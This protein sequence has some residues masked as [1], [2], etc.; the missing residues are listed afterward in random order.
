MENSNEEDLC[1]SLQLLSLNDTN[2]SP[3]VQDENRNKTD[4][5]YSNIFEE[6]V[7]R[8]PIK[9]LKS[10]FKHKTFKYM[11]KHLINDFKNNNN[12]SMFLNNI[13]SKI[14]LTL[15]SHYRG[16]Y[17]ILE[18]I[19]QSNAS[20]LGIIVSNKITLLNLHNFS[21][22][23]HTSILMQK[24]F[25]RSDVFLKLK[26]IEYLGD[27]L[28]DLAKSKYG[29]YLVTQMLKELAA[30]IRQNDQADFQQLQAVKKHYCALV[31]YFLQL[32]VFLK[33]CDQKFG[34]YIIELCTLNCDHYRKI[35]LLYD[36]LSIQVDNQSI[37]K[38]LANGKQSNYVIQKLCFFFNSHYIGQNNPNSYY[39]CYDLFFNSQHIKELLSILQIFR[40]LQQKPQQQEM[41]MSTS[42]LAL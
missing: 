15:C 5:P 9:L 28:C 38:H 37:L 41:S 33:L 22:D 39:Q 34:S 42:I 36:L 24:L 16:K 13:N 21:K 35:K 20:Q 7:L 40:D 10:C 3:N 27:H 2:K 8:S 29:N 4:K 32:T 11:M 6:Y 17:M 18:L 14:F 19:N 31:D 12:I 26:L 25:A 1:L 30:I 23:R